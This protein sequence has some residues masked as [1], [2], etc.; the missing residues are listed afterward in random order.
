[1]IGSLALL[2]ARH[3]LRALPSCLLRIRI[4]IAFR[5]RIFGGTAAIRAP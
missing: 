1:M 3:F 2:Y 4:T 5:G